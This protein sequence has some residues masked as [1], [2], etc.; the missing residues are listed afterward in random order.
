MCLYEGKVK[1]SSLAYNLHETWDK[2]PLDR[3]PDRNWCHLHTL[4]FLDT[5]HDSM[6]ISRSI[7]VCCHSVYGSMDYD[8]KSFT[9]VWWWHQLLSGSLPKNCL[10]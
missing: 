6:D 2:Y 9:L 3:D 7:Q 10:S 8:Q 1:I 4:A 5:A